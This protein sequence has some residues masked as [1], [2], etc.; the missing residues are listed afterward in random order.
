MSFPDCGCQRDFR[1]PVH[2]STAGACCSCFSRILEDLEANIGQRL[3]LL[4]FPVRS[5]KSQ[6]PER[7]MALIERL[8][9]SS[10]IVFCFK[11]SILDVGGLAP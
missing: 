1:Y 5:G 3:L 2:C 7:A 8:V 4:P 11:V 10:N 6:G 9:S